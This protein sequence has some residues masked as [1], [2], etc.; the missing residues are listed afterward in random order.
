M[1]EKTTTMNYSLPGNSSTEYQSTL[2]YY[3]QKVEELYKERLAWLSKF[4]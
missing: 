4:D 1:Q 2:S 3:K